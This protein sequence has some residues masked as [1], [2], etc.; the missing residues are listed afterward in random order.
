[1]ITMTAHSVS[2][3]DAQLKDTIEADILVLGDGPAAYISALA[4]ART[5]RRVAIVASPRGSGD[6]F[7]SFTP[8]QA[9]KLETLLG[10]LPLITQLADKGV[11][12]RR[13]IDALQAACL[14]TVQICDSAATRLVPHRLRPRIELADG[15]SLSGR[16]VVITTIPEPEL[17]SEL[18]LRRYVM[19]RAHLHLIR[20]KLSPRDGVTPPGD[21]ASGGVIHTPMAAGQARLVPLL[22]APQTF[23]LELHLYD[24][25][26]SARLRTFRTTPQAAVSAALPHLRV[27]L[28][29][30]S[31][32]G[33]AQ[34]R[35]CDLYDVARPSRS[36]VVLIGEARRSDC[37]ATG[38]MR[39]LD[40]L[41]ALQGLTPLWLEH[42]ADLHRLDAFY[43]DETRRRQEAA[44]HKRAMRLRRAALRVGPLQTLQRAAARLTHPTQPVEAHFRPGQSVRVRSA[45]DI[46]A[47]LDRAGRLDGLPFM[48]EMVAH[49]GAV[50]RIRRRA[51]R[52]CVEGEGLRGMRDTVF[53]DDAR[54]DG[55]SHDGCQRGCDAF[56]K[57]RWLSSDLTAP[58]TPDAAERA[59]RLRLLHMATRHG[60]TYLCQSTALKSAT[61]PLS[62]SH[63][64]V[65]AHEVW[66]GDI[67]PLQFM[68]LT[69]RALMNKARRLFGLPELD[70][71]VGE[72]GQKTRGALDL[73][74]GDWV[75]VRDAEAI[76]ATL[77]PA[78]RN[79]GLSFE[80]EMTLA[81]GQARQVDQVVT[82]IV[83]EITG[84]MV[85]L[86][87]TVTLKG[88]V[89]EGVC[90]KACPRANPLFWREAWLERIPAPDQEPDKSSSQS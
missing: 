42:G 75:R 79:L 40:D 12:E 52:A 27:W 59:A 23:G 64:G 15:R 56:W 36:G 17:F 55:Y 78:S 11:S 18:G 10:P 69:H 16:L 68:R 21:Q 25:P 19:S 4:L 1:V 86:S 29:G 85:T 58:A 5:G 82:R 90:A 73:K 67:R 20:L 46:L 38:D 88:L 63:I 44:A 77:D 14:K 43:A 41:S 7:L 30:C 39:L 51:G 33:A 84:E 48:P 61:H 45:V 9:Q 34:M 6:C 60:K 66:R 71:I 22:D 13:L 28:A 35:V 31:M 53:L 70:Q 65:L 49:I 83:H 74:P 3:P 87:R 26:D 8:E 80:P 72:A 37:P 54:C 76:R 2:A 50:K 81:I 62:Q 24:P 32:H 47:T 89:C 57:T